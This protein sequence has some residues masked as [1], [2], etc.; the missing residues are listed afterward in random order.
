VVS[1][2]H[3]RTHTHR[4][5]AMFKSGFREA[6]EHEVEISD[7]SYEAFRLMLDYIY[8]GSVPDVLRIRHGGPDETRY[9]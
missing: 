2:T 8:S 5:R 9:V 3:A 4:F 1:H 6:S 7:C